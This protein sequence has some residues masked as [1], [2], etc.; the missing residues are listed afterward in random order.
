MQKQ[1]A[2]MECEESS[3]EKE[4]QNSVLAISVLPTS[5]LSTPTENRDFFDRNYDSPLPAIFQLS[6][7]QNVYPPTF[8]FYLLYSH[9]QPW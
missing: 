8:S 5:S 3:T 4:K 1:F 7:N 2:R 9:Q 6:S